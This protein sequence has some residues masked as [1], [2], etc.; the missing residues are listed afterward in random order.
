MRDWDQCI[1]EVMGAY[2]STRHAT[3]G[4]SPYMLTRGVEE[5]IPLTFLY[6]E[7]AARSFETHEVY[8]NHVLARQQEIHDLVRRN[9]HQAQL[10]QKLKYHRAIQ[11]RAYQPGE[12]VW[13]FCRY[14]PQK[15][16]P[17]LMHAWRGPHKV[18]QVFQDGRVY[19]LDT[20]QKVHFERF[21]PHHSGPLELAAAPAD[22]GEV[23][24]LMD[25][26][27][28]RSVDVVDDDKSLPSYKSE[29]LL[30]EASD[31]SLPSRKRHWMDTRL[32][33]KLRAGGSRMH[34]QQFDYSTSST[35]DEL[36]DAML[37]VPPDP[38]DAGQAEPEAPPA[39]S[40]QSISPTRILPRL[41]SDHERVRSP[42]PQIFL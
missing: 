10:R 5:A 23:V 18:V 31:V 20:G 7:F 3:T 13:V 12:L 22:S 42:S 26:E 37:P 27:P 35:D 14:V 21:K 41:F 19:V 38:I 30:S 34:Y 16:S 11:A 33:T 17:K 8:V 4:F 24:V 9:T 36:S 15:G 25:P 39:A 29:Q 2:N 6:L 40:D 28:E 32:R 1:D